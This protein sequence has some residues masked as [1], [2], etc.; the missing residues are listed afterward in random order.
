MYAELD[1]IKILV[2]MSL[3]NQA[4]ASNMRKARKRAA[5]PVLHAAASSHETLGPF[6]W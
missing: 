2:Q 6:E 1:Q 3:R 5:P 4:S